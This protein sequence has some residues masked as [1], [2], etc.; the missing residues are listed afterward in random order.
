MRSGSRCAIFRGVKLL[1]HTGGLPGYVSR[2]TMVPKLK[3]G[4]AVLTNQESGAAFE[5]L[6]YLILDPFL[7]HPAFDWVAAI[8]TRADAPRFD[9]GSGRPEEHGHGLTVAPSRRSLSSGMLERIPTRGTVT[10]RSRISRGSCTS[11]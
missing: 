10:W 7:K 9:P 4:I 8:Q 3:L 2:V 5:A 6:T 1:T 11:A